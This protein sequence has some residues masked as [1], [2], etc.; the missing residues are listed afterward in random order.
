MFY[1]YFSAKTW[2]ISPLALAGLLGIGAYLAVLGRWLW[3][4]NRLQITSYPIEKCNMYCNYV[5]YFIKV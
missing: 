1:F 5:N 3:K 2:F 4:C